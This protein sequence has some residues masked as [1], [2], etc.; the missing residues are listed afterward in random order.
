M[1]T[2]ALN[3]ARYILYIAYTCGDCITNLKLQKL[4]Y[5]AQ[6][7]YLVNYKEPLFCNDIKAWQYGPVVSEV[8][9]EYKK[10]ANK[11]IEDKLA[12]GKKIKL[13]C[14]QKEYLK[15]FCES[16]FKYSATELIAMIHSET[17]WIKAYNN[18]PG[19]VISLDEMEKYYS[20]LQ[21]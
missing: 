14:E 19:S 6:A 20:S 10:F 17:P 1:N 16:F 5:Y 12:N 7:W 13:T 2:Y 3:V 11:P 15:E 18:R 8:Y 9:D 4:L 21:I